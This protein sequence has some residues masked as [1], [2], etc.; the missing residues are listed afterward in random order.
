MIIRAEPL[1]PFPESMSQ[2]QIDLTVP[3]R[4]SLR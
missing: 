3:I 4:F 1:P 2:T